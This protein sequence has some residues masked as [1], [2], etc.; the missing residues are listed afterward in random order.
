MR[1]AELEIAM[2]EAKRFLA[3]A[4]MLL[5]AAVKHNE[6]GPWFVSEPKEQ[7]AV[8]RSSLDLTRALADLRRA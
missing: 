7:G 5:T 2:T 6:L 8:R 4:E 3:R 1:K